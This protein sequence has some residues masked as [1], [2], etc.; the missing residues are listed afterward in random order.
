MNDIRRCPICWRNIPQTTQGNITRH[1]DS[2][3]RDICPMSQNPYSLMEI[4]RS[5][6]HTQRRITK[7]GAA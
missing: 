4:G 5:H 2:A 1:W 6:R 7:D 3:G